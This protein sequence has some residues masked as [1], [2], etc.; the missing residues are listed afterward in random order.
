MYEMYQNFIL[1][2][3]IELLNMNALSTFTYHN[4][5]SPANHSLLSRACIWCID[6]LIILI[7]PLPLGLCLQ[8]DLNWLKVS[9]YTCWIILTDYL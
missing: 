4:S 3:F 2:A 9:Y 8:I 5:L 6:S 7:S 1:L